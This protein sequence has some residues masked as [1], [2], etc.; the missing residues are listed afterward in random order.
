[1]AAA[2]KE[3]EQILAIEGTEEMPQGLT[4]RTNI[5]LRLQRAIEEQMAQNL[6]QIEA[7]QNPAAGPAPDS[8]PPLNPQMAPATN[9]PAVSNKPQLQDGAIVADLATGRVLAWVG[10]R[11]FSKSQFDHVSMARRE[12]GALLQPLIYALGFDRLNLSPASMINASFID[13]NAPANPADLALGNPATDLNRRFLCIQDAL[14]LGNRPAATRVGLQLG[15]K[16][17]V[18]WL[19]QS[20]VESARMAGEKPNQFNTGPMTLGDIAE[21]YQTLGNGGLHRKLKIIQ[22]IASRDGKVIYDDTRADHSDNK[23]ELLNRENDQQM[24]LTL[25]NA[26]R[27]GVARTLT[28]DFGLKP[29]IAGMP[30]YSEGYRDAWFV[31]YTPKLVTGIWVGYDDS[32]AIG[33]KDLATKA[34]VPMWGNVMQQVETRL[35]AGDD[36]EV[37]DNFTKVEI[38]RYSGALRGMA[39]LAPAAGDVFVYLKKDQVEGRAGSDRQRPVAGPAR[40]FRLAHLHVQ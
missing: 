27:T 17:F 6:A 4:V 8:V 38:D 37:P 36:F 35:P 19:R 2:V 7:A 25:Q 28:K 33:N 39:G 16:P 15:A 10:G 21:L 40:G 13:P 14:A 30:G 12:N 32:R 1:M 20:G 29:G 22:S 31:G 9:A 5:D 26:L 34:A 3:M 11:D 23:D 18:G 24:T